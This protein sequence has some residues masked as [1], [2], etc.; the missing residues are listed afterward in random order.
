MTVAPVNAP[1]RNYL[2]FSLRWLL[3]LV[4][5]GA[6]VL[7]IYRWQWED[8]RLLST[9]VDEA[10]RVRV[11]TYHYG[12]YG[13]PVRHGPQRVFALE[14]GVGDEAQFSEGEHVLDRHYRDGRLATLGYP[15]RQSDNQVVFAEPAQTDAPEHNIS[16]TWRFSRTMGGTTI[17]QRAAWRNAQRHGKTVWRLPDGQELQSAEFERG[18]VTRWNGA[19]VAEQ[20]QRWAARRVPAGELRR[21]LFTKLTGK[22]DYDHASVGDFGFVWIPTQPGPPFLMH[23]GF[24]ANETRHPSPWQPRFQERVFGEV[25]LECALSNWSTLDY[26]YGCLCTAPMSADLLNED[27][28]STQANPWSD[29]TGSDQIQFAAGTAA[30]TA[31]NQLATTD[32]ELHALPAARL[33]DLFRQ[34]DIQI[35]TTAVDHLDA[36]QA[37]GRAWSCALPYYPRPRRDLCGHI[38]FVHRYRCEQRAGTLVILAQQAAGTQHT[39]GP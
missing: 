7:A 3:V 10:E 25:L 20:L 1:R 14:T 29:P 5:L 32:P 35:D 8:I 34:T 6:I 24:S 22:H 36:P 12:W 26:R 39:M 13:K 2:Q 23:F 33:R 17:T 37:A 38:L 30:H 21:I 15:D 28:L 27:R 18:R 19:P 31:W 16:G 9:V 11:T 4:T